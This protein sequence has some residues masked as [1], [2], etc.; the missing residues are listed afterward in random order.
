MHTGRVA[1][2]MLAMLMACSPSACALETENSA[3]Y[4]GSGED[5]LREVVSCGDGLFAAGTTASDDEDLD[6]RT[7][8]GETGWAMRLNSDGTVRFHFCSGRAGMTRMTAPA[9]LADGIYSLVLT[10]EAG[11][12]GDWILIN[13]RGELLNRCAIPPLAALCSQAASLRQM[14]PMQMEAGAVLAL[15]MEHPDGQ[16]CVSCLHED[17]SLQQGEPF[18]GSAQGMA[19]AGRGVIAHASIQDGGIVITFVLPDEAAHDRVQ[20]QAVSGAAAIGDMLL[21]EDESVVLGGAVD[22]GGYLLRVSRAGEMLFLLQT[23]AAVTHLTETETGFAAL[24]GAEILFTDEDGMNTAVT[25]APENVLALAPSLGGVAALSHLTA[26]GR[27]QAVFTHIAQP[28]LQ[29]EKREAADA[30]NVPAG[31]A[32]GDGYLLCSASDLSGV[33]V[34]HVAADGTPLFATRTPIHTAADSLQ[35]CCAAMMD[36]GSI[37]LGGRYLTGEGD[38]QRQQAVCALLSSGGVLR[39]METIEGAGAVCAMEETTDGKILLHTA[40][41]GEPSL[42]ADGIIGLGI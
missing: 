24:A 13:D 35:W 28:D 41:E 29:A 7:R 20:V 22:E 12:R 36:D 2:L 9:A 14:L 4:G 33:L 30:Q 38:A 39:Q 18:T 6:M 11:Q 37:L 1:A 21:G 42:E 8:S 40:G 5:I 15:L 26:R 32:V 34:T 31:L 10:D 16:L 3:A 23:Q 17:G 27:R 19:A 25:A